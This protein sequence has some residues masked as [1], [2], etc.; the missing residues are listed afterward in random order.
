MEFPSFNND[1][2]E[3]D[4]DDEHLPGERKPMPRPPLPAS[5]EFEPHGDREQAQKDQAGVIY[6]RPPKPPIMELLRKQSLD[7]QSEA[8]EDETAPDEAPSVSTPA[9]PEVRTLDPRLE[10]ATELDRTL[11]VERPYIPISDTESDDD[12]DEDDDDEA[13]EEKPK[14]AGSQTSQLQSTAKPQPL[15]PERFE[16]LMRRNMDNAFTEATSGENLDDSDHEAKTEEHTDDAQ[17]A[18]PQTWHLPIESYQPADDKAGGDNTSEPNEANAFYY[19]EEPEDPD[20]PA[21]P[22]TTHAYTGGIPP[23]NGFG[24][25][26][27]FGG[28]GNYGSGAGG[29]GGNFGA[30]PAGGPM[31]RAAEAINPAALH[32][33]EMTAERRGLRRGLVAGFIT[34]WLLKSY[35]AKRKLQRFQKATKQQFKQQDEQIDRLDT[36]HR[37]TQDRLAATQEQ[38]NQMQREQAFAPRPDSERPSPV[39]Q[40]QPGET[41]PAQAHASASEAATPPGMPAE[42]PLATT[43]STLASQAEAYRQPL[44]S[45]GHPIPDAPAS[46]QPT[47]AAMPAEFAQA[48]NV[49]PG[50]YGERPAP[51]IQ[52]AT[53]DRYGNA[54]PDVATYGQEFQAERQREQI[55]LAAFAGHGN[56]GVAGSGVVSSDYSSIVTGLAPAASDQAQPALPPVQTDWNHELPPSLDRADAQ[57]LLPKG[58]SIMSTLAS[59]WLWAALIVL[60]VAF[61]VAAFI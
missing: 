27:G 47:G 57:H 2:Y 16:D 30:G 19:E 40:A 50:E 15:T 35:L 56:G 32:A 5:F 42:G 24:G 17:P 58:R 28:G 37:A 48:Y 26:T 10:G 34:G 6:L 25:G 52:N 45:D 46:E 53:V 59:P 13:D 60:L 51:G 7:A 54:V 18:G 61:F 21:P 1:Q 4:K 29:S 49:R 14:R 23:I 31:S 12:E 44:S 41:M 20:Q 11:A 33:A 3:S 9:D 39:L 43:G 38:L 22:A 8:P 55:D 36:E